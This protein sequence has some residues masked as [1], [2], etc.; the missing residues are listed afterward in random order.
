MPELKSLFSY[1]LT[2]EDI[3]QTEH[4]MIKDLKP[5]LFSRNVKDMIVIDVDEARIDDEYFSSIIL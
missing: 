5:L 1:T 2:Y 4:Y 3:S